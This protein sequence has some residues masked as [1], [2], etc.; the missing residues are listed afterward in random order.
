MMTNIKW[1]L[2]T[3][4]L[5]STVVCQAQSKFE[6]VVKYNTTNAAVNEV[7]SVTWHLKNGQNRLEFDSQAGENRVAYSLMM[8]NQ[9][10]EAF[11]TTGGA[12]Q[13]VSGIKA[14][15]KIAGAKF[16]RKTKVTEN[17]YECEML[18]FKSGDY[19]LVYWMTNDVP[20]AYEQLPHLVKNNMPK[21][22]GISNG[23]PVKMEIRDSKGTIVQSQD[24]VSVTPAKVDDSKFARK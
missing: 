9:E 7:A 23:F 24:V 22:S 3:L 15:E 19:E 8:D 5:F 4:I 1:V 18:M 14:D 10:K 13:Y 6:G 2:A 16:I 17:G 21:L 12:S 11:L 20:I